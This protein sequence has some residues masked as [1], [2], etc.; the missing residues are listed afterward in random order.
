MKKN[1]SEKTVVDVINNWI[2]F[3]L[4][5]IFIGLSIYLYKSDAIYMCGVV[6]DRP[7]FIIVITLTILR[8]LSKDL[9]ELF[10][11]KKKDD[12]SRK[13]RFRYITFLTV[14]LILLILGGGCWIVG[15]V[16]SS[17]RAA[18]AQGKL[19][20]GG[21]ILFIEKEMKDSKRDTRRYEI[22]VYYKTGFKMKEL[23]KF[24]EASFSHDQMIKNGQYQVEYSGNKVTVYYDYGELTRGSA[25]TEEAAKE[26]A[27]YIKQVYNIKK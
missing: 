13:E 2:L 18:I 21:S 17:K 1:N 27:K 3:F 4:A 26:N 25:W 24:S 15:D 9:Y 6:L 11:L 7:I 5:V 19:E 8:Y 10:Y 14:W 16:L 12:A 22:T 23:G 20:D